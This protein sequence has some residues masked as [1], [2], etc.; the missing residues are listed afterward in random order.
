MTRRAIDALN[1]ATS[2]RCP[3]SSRDVVWHEIGSAE[4]D[5]ARPRSCRRRRRG[6]HHGSARR[7]R[8]RRARR[9]PRQRP[10]R[11]AARPSPTGPPSITHVRDGKVT[12]RWAFSDDTGIVTSSGRPGRSPCGLSSRS[13]TPSTAR[14]WLIRRDDDND[15][16]SERPRRPAP[17]TSARS[18]SFPARSRPGAP[19]PWSST[20]RRD[21]YRCLHR[22]DPNSEAKLRSSRA[23]SSTSPERR[24]NELMKN[25]DATHLG[26][27]DLARGP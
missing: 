13:A 8:Q 12:E 4:P 9:R 21:G 18:P 3:S 7:R 1:R 25:V 11:A 2:R 5:V 14:T 15:D 22:H 23:S 10:P 16:V 19:L 27:E 17:S 6:P 24:S 26:P 20:V